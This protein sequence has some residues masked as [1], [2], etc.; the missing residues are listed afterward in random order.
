MVSEFYCIALSH[1]YYLSDHDVL[2]IISSAM[3]QSAE[4]FA[5]I[6]TLAPSRHMREIT[7]LCVLEVQC[8]H[9]ICFAQEL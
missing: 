5:N 3:E 1:L 9:V 2:S 4:Y 8:G 7:P 6:W